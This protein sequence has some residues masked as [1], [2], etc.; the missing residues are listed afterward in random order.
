M[1]ISRVRH[2][3]NLFEIKEGKK[4]NL[5]IDFFFRHTFRNILLKAITIKKLFMTNL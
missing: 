3:H 4:N 5:K 2:V 1:R